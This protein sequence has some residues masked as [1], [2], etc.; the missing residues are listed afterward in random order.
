MDLF[1]EILPYRTFHLAVGNGHQLYVEESGITDG[2]PV[3]FLHGGPG[4]GSS[5]YHRR[6][7]DPDRYRIVVF[8]QRGCGRSSPHAGLSHNTT[9]DLVN[10]IEKIRQELQIGQWL[11]FGGSWGSSLALAYAQ[12]YPERVLGLILRGIF[13]CRNR[14]I[15]WFYQAGAS[16]IL[17]EAWER[18]IRPIP[19]PERTD[20]VSAYYKRLTGDDE[21]QRMSAAKAW[22][23]WEGTA[24]TL[25]Q[26]A[27]TVARFSDP[28]TALA[29]ARIENYYFVNH[30]FFEE[31]QLLAGAGALRDIPGVIVHGRYDVVCPVSQAWAL[32]NVWRRAELN[33]IEDAGHAAT[34]PGIRRALVAATQAMADRL[35]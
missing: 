10:D 7:F 1:P 24:A 12:Q 11:V 6:F 31:N 19:E 18:F 3:I 22:S 13:L 35:A 9:R 26:D 27:T 32:H 16:E 28:K 2:L 29:L 23:I 20:M 14:D 5:P 4:S 15:Q 8:D 30:C 17:P 25:R 21:A 33:I 34:E